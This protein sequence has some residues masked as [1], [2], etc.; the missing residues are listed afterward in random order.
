MTLTVFA[1]AKINLYLHV[2]KRLQN[3]YHALDSLIGFADIGDKISV[4]ESDRLSFSIDGEMAGVLSGRDTDISPQ[5]GNLV[6]RAIWQMAQHF[7]RAP[8]LN[9][10]LSKNL[11]A[12]AGIGGGSSDAASMIWA[13]CCLWDIPKNA[14]NLAAIAEIM[15]QLGADVPVCFRAESARV[16]GI[17]DVFT[18][19]P[20]LPEM[21]VVLVFPAKP[22]GTVDVFRS[23][24][25]GMKEL[26]AL[27]NAFEDQDHVIDFL[28]RCENDLLSSAR[29]IVPEIDNALRAIEAQS[30]CALSRMS[31]SGSCCFG[32]FEN[33]NQAREAAEAIEQE[34]P[35]WWVK[36][37]WI[38]RASRY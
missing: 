24:Q 36:P 4:Q 3:G 30:G 9:V 25:G 7:E 34:N 17:G 22:C 13:L 33:E 2:T 14:A 12:G 35:D 21:P 26:V 38:G 29:S 37:G 28:S 5:S 15:I 31:G 16:K 32:I 18:P 11:P 20:S 10:R 23:Y 27:P 8:N 19:C 6:V 1:P